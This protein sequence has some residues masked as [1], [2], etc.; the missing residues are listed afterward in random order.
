M[1]GKTFVCKR[2]KRSYAYPTAGE[3]PIRCECG[4]WYFNDGAGIREAYWQRIEP[5]RM[6]P[7]LRAMF[8]V[9]F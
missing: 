4:W 7:D 2:C 3:R 8:K 5:Y 9:E 6:P 1:A